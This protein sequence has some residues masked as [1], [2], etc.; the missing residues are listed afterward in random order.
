M[1]GSNTSLKSYRF[2]RGV[3]LGASYGSY[4]TSPRTLHKPSSVPVLPKIQQVLKEGT[5]TMT[6]LYNSLQ[7]LVESL[8]VICTQTKA[9][10][11]TLHS[12]YTTYVSL[13]TALYDLGP[14][15]Q[16]LDRSHDSHTT[17]ET[18]HVMM[19]YVMMAVQSLVE[20]VDVVLTSK[21][22]DSKER[23][24]E[25]TKAGTHTYYTPWVY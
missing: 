4:L 1:E 12:L 23:S 21:S 10:G 15:L 16:Q 2:P 5:P 17:E 3:D 6:S 18:L 14:V 11:C 8:N 9:R 13:S 25:H 19:V 24:H 20:S 22:S 7:V